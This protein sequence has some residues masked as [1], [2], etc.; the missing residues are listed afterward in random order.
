MDKVANNLAVARLVY[1]R[2]EAQ[3]VSAGAMEALRKIDDILAA[4]VREAG[5]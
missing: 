1:R 3:G 4:I 5:Q 2:V